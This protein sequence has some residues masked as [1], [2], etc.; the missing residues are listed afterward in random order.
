VAR[1]KTTLSA[2]QLLNALLA[3]EQKLGRERSVK[4]A[5][6]TLDLDLLLYADEVIDEPDLQVPHPRMHERFFV[7][8]PLLQ[9]DSRV[10]DPRTGDPFADAY[11]RLPRNL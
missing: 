11:A 3:V 4:N 8:W 2:R 6:R 7:L 5:P 1:L 10:R 9:I